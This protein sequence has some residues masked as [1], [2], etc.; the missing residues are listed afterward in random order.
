[1]IE[2]QAKRGDDVL[3]LQ[4]HSVCSLWVRWW[5]WWWLSR[6]GKEAA[7]A[8][9]LY[10]PRPEER[11]GEDG[12]ELAAKEAVAQCGRACALGWAWAMVLRFD[13]VLTSIGL[14]SFWIWVGVGYLYV[15]DGRTIYIYM[16][17]MTGQQRLPPACSL[18]LISNLVANGIG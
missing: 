12:T 4:M 6:A 18:S 17:A 14:A 2:Q 15:A 1:M 8:V 5:W 3:L 13:P 7:T 9:T 11:A 16:A 10:L